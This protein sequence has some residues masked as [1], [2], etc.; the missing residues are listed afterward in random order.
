MSAIALTTLGEQRAL[1][2]R[3]SG[4]EHSVISLLYETGGPVDFEEIMEALHTDEEK[5]SMI[6]RRMLNAQSPLI[7]E[8]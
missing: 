3:G 1:D 7:K 2:V 6:I 8:L 4:P 5:A